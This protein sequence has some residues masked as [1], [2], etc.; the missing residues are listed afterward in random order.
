VKTRAQS[1]SGK[2]RVTHPDRVID[3]SSGST[4]IQLA[5]YYVSVAEWI[6]PALQDRPVALVRAP[7]GIAG[8]LFFQKNV[9]RMAIPGI[10]TV[11]GESVMLINNAEALVGAVQMSTIEF[12]SWI[13]TAPD[14]DRPDRFALDLDPDPALPCPGRAWWRPRPSP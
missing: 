1:S 12:Y 10:E 8:E 11:E 13:A 9:E 4:K 2:I 14:L 7:E 6:L 3:A 5:E